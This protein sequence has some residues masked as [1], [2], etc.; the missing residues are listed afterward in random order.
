[1]QPPALVAD[2]YYHGL[3]IVRNLG[4]RGI[5]VIGIDSDPKAVG[6]RSRFSKSMVCPSVETNEKEHIE[7]LVHL[8]GE[9]NGKPVLFPAA[10]EYVHAYARHEDVLREH[11]LFTGPDSETV[12]KVLT[13]DA[14]YKT[15]VESGVRLPKT[16]LVNSPDDVSNV[17]SKVPY[18]CLIKPEFTKLWKT[19]A[20]RKVL[21]GFKK[22][23]VAQNP[24]DLVEGYEKMYPFSPDVV[25]SEVI[26]GA[27]DRLY[28]FNFYVSKDGE[29]LGKLTGKK[30]RTI[31]NHFGSASFVVTTGDEELDRIATAFLRKIDYRGLGGLE[32]KKDT[33]DG[34]FKL[35]ELNPRFGLWQYTGALCGVDFA[36]LAYCDAI[37]N[38]PEPA[39]EVDKKV[40]WVSVTRDVRAFWG[41]RREGTLDFAGW[42]KSFKGKKLWAVFSFDD[43]KPFLRS[44]KNDSLGFIRSVIKKIL[45]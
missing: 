37:G 1:M 12:G 5:S 34:E 20:A 26:P 24:L 7:F 32:F 6:L 31:P 4:R 2:L 21:G 8:S 11:Y 10:D 18:P 29:V 41:L 14:L 39:R 43:L 9:L 38:R 25:V 16:Y 44:L 33:R 28:Y 15:A 45:K 30:V 19:E 17:A 22:V 3:G 27:D 36:Y 13:K 40:K 35:I 42:I 23:I